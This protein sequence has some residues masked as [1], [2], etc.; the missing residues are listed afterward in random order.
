MTYP[1]HEESDIDSTPERLFLFY[2]E[3]V[4]WAYVNGDT[5]VTYNSVGYVPTV[6]G[7]G[8]YSQ[9]L[10]EDSPVISI[11]ISADSAVVQQ[12]IPYQPSNPMRVRV[13]RHHF[14]DADMEFKAEVIGKVVNCE[15]DKNDEMATLSI[16]LSGNNLDRKTPWPIYQKQC[17]YALYGPGCQV[18]RFDFQTIGVLSIVS[19]DII[20]STDFASKPDGWFDNGYVTNATGEYRY[21]VHHEGD[22][23]WL[24]T[25]FVKAL[26]GETVFAYAGC[27]RLRD[28]CKDKFDNLGRFLGFPWVPSKNP[29]ADSVYG[30][31]GTSM[32]S[33]TGT[34]D[35]SQRPTGN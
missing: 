35:T 17:N 16:R 25:P 1:A 6:V 22:Q 34:A 27:T 26:P 23:I 7:L 29:Y 10:A 24:Q 12:F 32:Q 13:Y 28:M 11:R 14:E 19:T 15:I 31:Q 9:S 5:P 2:M 21:I 30:N 3:N 20:R 8:D 4:E 18:N 33:G